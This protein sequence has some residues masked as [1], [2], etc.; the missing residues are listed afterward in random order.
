MT[1]V[2]TDG[3][4]VQAHADDP[5]VR[6]I[7]CGRREAY[8]RAHLPGAVCLDV[9]DEAIAQPLWL[10]DGSDPHAMLGAD[11]LAGLMRRLGVSAGTTVVAYDD[12]DGLFAARLWWTLHRH[13]HRAVR[14]LDGG[15][16]GWVAEGRPVSVDEPAVEPGD[17]T[18]RPA[19]ALS[20][21]ADELRGRLNDPALRLLDVRG[22]GEWTG[23]DRPGGQRG[24]HLPGAVHLHW[25]RLLADD[26][27][28]RMRSPGEIRALLREAGL[29]PAT[30]TV[31]YC[32][33]A[34]RA[35]HTALALTLAG[36][37]RVRVYEGSM[38]EWAGRGDT[39]LLRED[40]IG[41]DG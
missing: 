4:R 12:A 41:D 22:E 39:P 23:R 20:C 2:L 25:K 37:E 36:W 35:A 32:Q 10:K 29:D 13:G 34:V 14:V 6:V 5:R 11:E 24:G 15:W 8:L 38:A 28:G 33:A 26:G 17:W 40:G 19:E 7:D 21:G 1:D 18:A 30:E 9:R 3:A 27:S 16:R 31:T